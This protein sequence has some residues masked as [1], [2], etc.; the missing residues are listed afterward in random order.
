MRSVLCC[1]LAAGCT[2]LWLNRVNVTDRQLQQWMPSIWVSVICTYSP[3]IFFFL[4][5]LWFSSFYSCSNKQ[6]SKLILR[7]DVPTFVGIK[8]AIFI[9]IPPSIFIDS[10]LHFRGSW[11][12]H[13]QGGKVKL[14]AETSP[15]LK[16]FKYVTSTSGLIHTSLAAEWIYVT[17]KASG[18]L[19]VACWPLVPKFAGSNP[20]EAVGF[21][22]VKK[23]SA[24]LLS[25]GK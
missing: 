6:A 14:V 2:C 4:F 13:L 16:L 1:V 8:T 12:L 7:I 5:T 24:R 15:R 20:A 10:Y 9:D 19:E 22:R 18:G 23:S 11:C 21:F 25:E 3:N 17:I